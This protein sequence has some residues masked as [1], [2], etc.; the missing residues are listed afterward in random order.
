[1]KKQIIKT[2][3]LI[4]SVVTLASQSH[5]SLVNGGF[6]TGDFTG[7]TVVLTGGAANIVSIH[8]GQTASGPNGYNYAPVTGNYFARVKTDGPGN[9]QLV[10]QSLFLSVGSKLA[11]YAAFDYGDYHNFNDMA[12]VEI[13]DSANVVVA[14]PWQVQGN[15]VPNYSD[16]PWT[17]W[18]WTAATAGT[19]TLRYSIANSLDSN[20][21]SYALFDA[22]VLVPEPSTYLTGALL[23]LPFGVSTLRKLRAGRQG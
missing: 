2:V 13:L 6:E 10:S 5:A 3:G 1:M 19:Y 12:R 23:L 14:T 15:D 11:G 4:C 9:F 22:T 17:G 8:T 21:D 7:W 16:G 18:A 20:L